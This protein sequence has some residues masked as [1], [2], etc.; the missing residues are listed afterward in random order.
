MRSE[1]RSHGTSW[2]G[3]R[4]VAIPLASTSPILRGSPKLS[5]RLRIPRAKLKYVFVFKDAG[6]LVPLAGSRGTFIFY[7]PQ[8]YD[9][10]RVRQRYEGPA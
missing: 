8:D 2:R 7:A 4:V 5:K 6:D 10:E 3:S 1:A 9:V